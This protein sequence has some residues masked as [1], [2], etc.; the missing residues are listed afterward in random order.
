M[1]T[2]G[3]GSIAPDKYM[4]W[5]LPISEEIL[6]PS[7]TLVLNIKEGVVA[8]ERHTSVIKLIL[9]LERRGWLLAKEFI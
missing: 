3:R 4:E 6:K 2:G 7:G 1:P 8:G 5:F 9:A